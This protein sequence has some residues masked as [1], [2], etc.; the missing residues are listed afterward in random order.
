M[1]T[2]GNDHIAPK[3][4][5]LAAIGIFLVAALNLAFL[6]TVFSPSARSSQDHLLHESLHNPGGAP[7]TTTQ[8][9]M[10]RVVF[11]VIIVVLSVAVPVILVWL[12]LKTRSG[13]RWARITVTVML[14]FVLLSMLGSLVTPGHEPTL[15]G[16]LGGSIQLVAHAAVLVLLWL[17]KDSRAFFRGHGPASVGKVNSNG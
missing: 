9:E 15:L 10:A 17:P 3:S 13:R 12:G 1:T 5:R 11:L 8:F 16:A 6:W 2:N 7:V 4:V 14:T